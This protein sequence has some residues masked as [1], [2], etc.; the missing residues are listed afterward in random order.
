MNEFE[1]GRDGTGQ[2]GC[3][4]FPFFI[5]IILQYLSWLPSS[6]ELESTVRISTNFSCTI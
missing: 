5:I 2:D 4:D 3:V 1:V 6:L